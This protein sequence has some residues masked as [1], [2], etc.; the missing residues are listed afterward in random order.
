LVTRNSALLATA[1]KF[2]QAR[3]SPPTLG[4]I[5]GEAATETPDSYF[6]EVAEEYI[7]R[8]DLVVDALSGV[9][10]VVCPRPGGAFY[11]M[12]R[13][14]VDDADRFCQWLLEEFAL[15]GETVML[16]PGSGFYA[17]PGLGRNEV[18]IAYVLNRQDLARAMNCLKEALV[19]YPGRTMASKNQVV[20]N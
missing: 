5:L 16:A 9:D 3:L 14:P 11:I 15:E 10:G 2:A 4:Q 1:M 8:R 20:H 19:S 12:A 13:L 7:S 6:D 18:R 17:T